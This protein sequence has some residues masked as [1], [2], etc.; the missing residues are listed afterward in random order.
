MQEF[1][2]AIGAGTADLLWAF[3]GSVCGA[4]LLPN[5]TVRQV[6]ATIFVGTCFGTCSGPNLFHMVGLQPNNLFT[7]LIGSGGTAALL[8]GQ[9]MLRKKIANGGIK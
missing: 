8:F 1:L 6:F 7:F 3:L 9:E 4:F 2:T 5:P